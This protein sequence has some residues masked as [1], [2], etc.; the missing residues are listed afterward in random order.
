MPMNI[1]TILLSITCGVLSGAAASSRMTKQLTELT[2]L[3]NALASMQ[4][5]ICS[6]GAGFSEAAN[7]ASNL[8]KCELIQNIAEA[9]KKVPCDNRSQSWQTLVETSP[10]SP[11]VR[12]AL[13]TLF[14]CVEKFDEEAINRQFHSAIAT[15]AR[16]EEEL[17]TKTMRFM[18]LYRKV[19][20][21]GGIALAILLA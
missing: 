6:Y 17:R 1:I 12:S 18:P 16:C 8:H 21:L 5:E 7:Y 11:E 4:N 14:H 2:S 19:G 9:F 20:L 3:H 10:Y 15:I 13:L